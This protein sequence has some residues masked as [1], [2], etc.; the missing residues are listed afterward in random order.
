MCSGAAAGSGEPRAWRGYRPNSRL[1]PRRLA[2]GAT[3][4]RPP[5]RRWPAPG[6]RPVDPG[7]FRGARNVRS[8][9]HW[10]GVERRIGHVPCF[11]ELPWR[12][13]S[14]E[15]AQAMRP[16]QRGQRAAP[17]HAVAGQIR[18]RPDRE[19]R[20]A[21]V[22]RCRTKVRADGEVLGRRRDVQLARPAAPA[23]AGRR[24]TNARD[25]R[26]RELDRIT[27]FDAAGAGPARWGGFHAWRPCRRAPR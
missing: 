9:R 24:T 2:L 11:R 6:S 22:G 26:V 15:R 27:E 23:R 1:R 16:A 10:I 19:A 12:L 5:Q 4:S 8:A 13:T 21:D 25:R 20:P 7:E 14:S 18:V 17:R 3:L